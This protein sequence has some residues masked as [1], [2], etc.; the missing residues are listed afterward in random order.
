MNEPP[1]IKDNPQLDMD[2]GEEIDWTD[3]TFKMYP[4]ISAD[5]KPVLDKT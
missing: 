4:K 1:I 5:G 3:D 2:Y